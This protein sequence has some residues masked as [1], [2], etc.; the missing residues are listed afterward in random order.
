MYSQYFLMTLNEDV[1]ISQNSK[2][3][4]GH[5]SKDY[6][7]GSVLLGAVA[8]SL[9]SHKTQQQAWEFFHSGK[10][11]FGNALP[12]S[13]NGYATYPVPRSWF[14][15][16]DKKQEKENA[17][18]FAKEEFPQGEPLEQ[19]RGKYFTFQSNT[20]AELISPVS[21]YQM[22]T[23]ID[24]DKGVAAEGELFG[25]NSLQADQRF[26]FRIDS[27]DES[28]LDEISEQ[29]LNKPIYLGKSRSAEFGSVSI[30]ELTKSPEITPP[31]NE[32][33]QVILWLLA[34]MLIYDENG[35][36]T[37]Q[38]QGEA[39]HSSMQGW[40]LD[41]ARSFIYKRRIALFNAKYQRRELERE[42]IGM[43]SVLCFTPGDNTSQKTLSA[44]Q[45][46]EI[47]NQG[48]G[49]Y[50]QLG[51]GQ[52]WVNPDLLNVAEYK[53]S[54]N[55]ETIIKEKP[56]YIQEPKN[57]IMR[58]LQQRWSK[59]ENYQKLDI[60]AEAWAKELTLLYHSA[61]NLLPHVQNGCVGPSPTQ[62]GR[63]MEASK[64]LMESPPD[65]VFRELFKTLF[66]KDGIC[67]KNDPQWDAEVHIEDGGKQQLGSFRIWFMSKVKSK[68]DDKQLAALVSRFAHHAK[69]VALK[70]S[71]TY[72][73][74]GE[75]A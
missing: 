46:Q 49:S 59:Q 58:H 19:F 25:Y 21:N 18:N 54:T 64:N 71:C 60:T 29:L 28:V 41:F 45:L 34:D 70:S 68:R 39:I 17:I 57:L 62:W 14:C 15:E 37:L 11:R 12:V 31:Q 10:V 35:I 48:I 8:D 1:V 2:T 52:V 32:A 26:Y 53:F 67:K 42:V 65:Y 38:P 5:I 47:Q 27:E 3:L 24:H 23:S 69:N 13:K 4:G 44:E 22:K 51:L 7:P 16:K 6:I 63:V 56:Q 50:R 36:P 43:G 73:D 55:A 72:A 33:S 20:D 74:E 30:T 75:Q 9:Y 66:D 40:H 61:R